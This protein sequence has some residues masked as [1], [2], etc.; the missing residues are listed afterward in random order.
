M[1]IALVNEYSKNSNMFLFCPAGGSIAH[2]TT[3]SR[4]GEVEE[5]TELL[6]SVAS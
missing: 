1:F 4:K 6:A 3:V 5:A 2:L